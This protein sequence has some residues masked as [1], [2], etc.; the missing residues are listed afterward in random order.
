MY[1]TCKIVQALVIS[2]SVSREYPNLVPARLIMSEA[3]ASGGAGSA[4][5]AKPPA[6]LLAE[7]IEWRVV[8]A[9]WSES[10][11][12]GADEGAAAAPRREPTLFE[13]YYGVLTFD[14]T[15]GELF[16]TELLELKGAASLLA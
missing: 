4:F 15:E 13:E 7:P 9:L 2:F 8:D 14:G 11:H 6:G 10:D 1:N 12:T 3:L 5:A 16:P